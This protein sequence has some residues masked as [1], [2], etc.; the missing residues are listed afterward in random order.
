M[1]K[2]AAIFLTLYSAAAFAVLEVSVVKKAEDAFPVCY[3][4]IFD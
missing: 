4:S 2:L 3:F 1:I